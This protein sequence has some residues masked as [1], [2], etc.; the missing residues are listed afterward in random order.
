MESF[1]DIYHK[2]IENGRFVITYADE[3]FAPDDKF[4]QVTI[5]SVKYKSQY[6]GEV[7][8]RRGTQVQC[9]RE[10]GKPP[11]RATVVDI[12]MQYDEG[13]GKIVLIEFKSN[14]KSHKYVYIDDLISIY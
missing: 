10:V 3:L 2:R 5:L 14:P 4:R 11:V 12:P 13:R 6:F 7:V 8:I 9:M 1:S